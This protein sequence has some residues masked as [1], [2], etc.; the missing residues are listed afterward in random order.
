MFKNEAR[1]FSNPTTWVKQSSVRHNYQHFYPM[2]SLFSGYV[3]D[4]RFLK[5]DHPS[6][7]T[8]PENQVSLQSDFKG[9]FLFDSDF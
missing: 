9:F 5:H 3:Y 2:R 4:V 8:H 6:S 7:P 1:Q